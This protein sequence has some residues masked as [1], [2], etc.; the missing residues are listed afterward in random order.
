[1]SMRVC[2]CRIISCAG[3]K[4]ATSSALA[5]EATTNLIIWVMERTAPLK[6]E[7]GS[8]SER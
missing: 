4:S 5:A 6:H 7:K 3:M 8:F 1:M 2:L